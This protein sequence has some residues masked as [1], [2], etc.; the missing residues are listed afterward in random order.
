MLATRKGR[1]TYSRE[2][3]FRAIYMAGAGA[4]ASEIADALKTTPNA[5]Y[6]LMG[7]LGFRLIHKCAEEIA[8]PLVI[9]RE[10][11]A[12]V[13]RLAATKDADPNWQLSKTIGAVYSDKELTA[14]IMGRI[15]K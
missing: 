12:F 9:R 7:K 4:S 5:V 1:E 8:F 2:E 3:L 11:F 14:T 6:I 13:G 15:F 10:H